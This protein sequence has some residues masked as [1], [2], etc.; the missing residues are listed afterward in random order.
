[1]EIGGG[2]GKNTARRHCSPQQPKNHAKWEHPRSLNPLLD[3]PIP[4]L[5]HRQHRNLIPRPVK[6]NPLDPHLRQ[7]PVNILR[8]SHSRHPLQHESQHLKPHV[9]VTALLGG[10]EIRVLLPKFCKQ[11]LLPTWLR[12]VARREV[13]SL[14][15]FWGE[16][17]RFGVGEGG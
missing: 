10:R 12:P 1:M 7:H 17:E 15:G 6:A 11:V 2:C 13:E 3:I 14:A 9:T 5:P 16:A 8:I 4:C